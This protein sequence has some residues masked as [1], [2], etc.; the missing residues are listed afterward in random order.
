VARSIVARARHPAC[1]PSPGRCALAAAVLALLS[2]AAP[3]SARDIPLDVPDL[4]LRFDN[5]LRANVGIRTDPV[6]AR[7]SASP[8]FTGSEYGVEHGGLSAG[9]LDL[10]SEI[11]LAY[12]DRH[13]ARV[14]GAF[15]Y[16]LAYRG[17]EVS[18]DPALAGVPGSYVGDEYSD[19]TRHRYLGP[20]G[21]LL[22]AF[23][24]ARVE[25]GGV[26]IT[27]KAGRHTLYW[28]EALMLGGATH[29][30]SYSQM[31]L[32]L[33]KGLAVPGT[34]AKELFR[35]IASV[36]AQAQ[37]TPSLS[38]AAQ[39][40]LEWQPYLYPEGATFLA[41]GDFGFDGP[42]G[43]YRPTGPTSGIYLLNGGARE[44][45][46]LGEFGV[47]LRWRPDWLDG[48]V[49][50]YYRRYA[51]KFAAVLL[52]ANPGGQG[53]LSPDVSSPYRYDQY[54]AEGVDLVGASLAKQVLGVSV[55]LEASYRI[56]TPLLAQTL[57][58]AVAPAPSPPAP[59]EAVLFPHGPP[60]L[61]ENSYQAR[62]DTLHGVLNAIGVLKAPLFSVA[63]WA[64]EVTYSRWLEVR[65]N[66]DMFYAEGH[67]VCRADPALGASART[68]ADGCATRD[69]VGIGAGFTPTWY[70]VFPGVDLSMPLSVSWTVRGNSPVSMGGNEDS[71]SYA[72]GIAADVRSRH[73]L[74]LRYADYFGLVRFG[75]PVPSGNGMMALLESRGNV[76]FT[77]KTTF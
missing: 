31:P 15:W 61:V 7:L 20:W 44:P 36:S 49:G 53:P 27:V 1:R 29:G 33:Q 5:T 37:L 10:L 74:E 32:D 73:R 48:T 34:E 47:A 62:G 59:S 24:F 40:F 4:A 66:P 21:E 54:Y 30:V 64:L 50:L 11:D 71:G 56:D 18:R 60:R 58:F 6:D 41:A 26:P 57:G 3:V 70:R 28:G 9:R 51:D 14:S 16:D 12:R 42:D 8:A 55:G 25:P 65:D 72:L 19:Y 69:H 17:G 75:G 23:V 46:D 35:P 43:V 76:T 52:T 39:V 13:G 63:S 22:D 67:G 45:D 68:K 38:L 2:P 77:A